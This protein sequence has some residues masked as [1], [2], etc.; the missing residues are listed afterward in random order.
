MKKKQFDVK[1][2]KK[3]INEY[4][5]KIN[6]L[7]RENNILKKQLEDSNISLQINKDLLYSHIKS[8]KNISEEFESILTDLKKENER[9][10]D[11]IALLFNEKGELSKKLY[12]LQDILNDKLQQDNI[13]VE[14]ERTEKFLYEN[15]LK[16]K[17]YQ[18][19]N[20]KKQI[21]YLKKNSKNKNLLNSGINEIYIGDPN[22]FNTEINNELTMSRAIIKKY[23][24]LMQ[25]ERENTKK[26]KNKIDTLEDK[27]TS[28]SNNTSFINNN[29]KSINLK[30]ELMNEIFNENN[31]IKNNSNEGISNISL[32]FDDSDEDKEVN[33]DLSLLKNNNIKENKRTN[34]CEKIRNVP[35]LDFKDVIQNYKKPLNIKVVGINE[36]N[37]ND[38]DLDNDNKILNQKYKSKIQIYKNSIEKYKEKVK[39]LKNQIK[40]LIEKNSLL[41][42]TLKIYINKGN[43]INN[44]KQVKNEDISMNNNINEISGLSTN[45]IIF[46][47]GALENINKLNEINKITRLN[48]YKDSLSNNNIKKDDPLENIIIKD[49]NYKYTIKESDKITT[50]DS[51]KN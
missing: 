29:R 17:E 48:Q 36:I 16:E 39:K 18:I 13:I 7:S 12:K 8:K 34:T 14:K 33:I 2:A 21:E 9:L 50:N 32:S 44:K 6:L 41:I 27:V 22:R 23:I 4:A 11:K 3:I 38:M 24:Y 40:I 19:N 5:Q 43:N 10:N 31:L 42:N 20:L 49:T 30:L 15:K 45:S 35:K 1:T 51:S 47:G 46:K 26:L 37:S 25:E 28:I